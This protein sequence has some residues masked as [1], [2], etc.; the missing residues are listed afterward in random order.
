VRTPGKIGVAGQFFQP[1]APQLVR[2][3]FRNL[4]RHDHVMGSRLRQSGVQ[5]RPFYEDRQRSAYVEG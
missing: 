2:P 5:V 4:G 1:D 3:F